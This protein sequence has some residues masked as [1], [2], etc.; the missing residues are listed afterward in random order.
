MGKAGD[1]KVAKKVAEAGAK[2]IRE[3]IAEMRRQGRIKGKLFVTVKEGK[4]RITFPYRE[5]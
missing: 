2:M 4:R 5:G 3:Y 1:L